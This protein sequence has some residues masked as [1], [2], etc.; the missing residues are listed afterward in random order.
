MTAFAP[1]STTAP[2]VPQALVTGWE[3]VYRHYGN[4]SEAASRLPQVD[5]ATARGMSQASW[6]VASSWRGIA[7]ASQLP[8]WVLAA[9]LA[10][11]EA[12]D[13]QSQ[14]WDALSQR[15]KE[16][17]NAVHRDM[18]ARTERGGGRAD[19]RPYPAPTGVVVFLDPDRVVIGPP[20]NRDEWP[21]F[22]TFLRDMRDALDNLADHLDPQNE[23]EYYE[24]L[25]VAPLNLDATKP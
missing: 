11:A 1:K 20:H 13:E 9:V 3:D 15:A 12:F 4:A 23:S 6:A 21:E 18:R 24:R 25:F 10:A 17:G 14:Y 2:V 16:Q 8:W 19:P 5:A 22:L 7:S